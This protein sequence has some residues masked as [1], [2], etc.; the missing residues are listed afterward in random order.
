MT[1]CPNSTYASSHTDFIDI[2]CLLTSLTVDIA[3]GL[4]WLLAIENIPALLY[5]IVKIVAAWHRF[6]S[7][8]ALR[9]KLP[10]PLALG[11]SCVSLFTLSIIAAALR[12]T[13]ERVGRDVALTLIMVVW[14]VM[15]WLT[16]HLH[17]K[18][19]LRL[20][21]SLLPMAR[22]VELT[23]DL[24]SVYRPL[25][26]SFILSLGGPV[27]IGAL[28][29]ATDSSSVQHGL[30]IAYGCYA[31]AYLFGF[32]TLVSRI[33]AR[34]ATILEI[35]AAELDGIAPS[36]ASS[37]AAGGG[38]PIQ[39]VIAAAKQPSSPLPLPPPSSAVSSSAAAG[40]ISPRK[41]ASATPSRGAYLRQP[42]QRIRLASRGFLMVGV[43]MGTSMILLSVIPIL[44]NW[45]HLIFPAVLLN[46]IFVFAPILHALS[47]GSG[48]GNKSD[49]AAPKTGSTR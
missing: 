36:S 9:T 32:F 16:V 4:W 35:A 37:T 29:S 22:Q 24:T 40:S 19:W 6:G 42:L 43:N 11:C 23:S 20:T 18:L 8:T 44:R 47:F 41:Q 1:D 49:A 2:P 28:L 31:G 30:M 5:A 39:V 21:I 13:G 48:V 7:F 34:L 10:L 46:A 33:G 45:Y 3:S 26:L 25:P 17:L 27:L 38:V 15:A 12:L 14:L